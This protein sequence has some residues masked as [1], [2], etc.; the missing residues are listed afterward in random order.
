MKKY[1]KYILPALLITIGTNKLSGIS[2]KTTKQK[3]HTQELKAIDEKAII[4]LVKLYNTRKNIQ[5]LLDKKQTKKLSQK[6]KVQLKKHETRIVTYNKA[7]DNLMFK[8]DKI[9]LAMK[10]QKPTRKKVKKQSP[11]KKK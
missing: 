8:R 11:K 9:M 2:I 4:K 7:L 1:I 6:E 5:K 3:I 10:S